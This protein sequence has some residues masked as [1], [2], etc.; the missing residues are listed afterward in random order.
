MII[1]TNTG[2]WVVLRPGTGGLQGDVFMPELFSE[3]Y[4]T[5][6]QSWIEWKGHNTIGNIYA[7]DPLTGECQELGRK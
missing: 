3:A 5:Q 1:K 2:D 7:M 4:E 6:L